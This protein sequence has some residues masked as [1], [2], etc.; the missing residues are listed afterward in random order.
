L[1]TCYVRPATSSVLTGPNLTYASE[2]DVLLLQLVKNNS[3]L[4]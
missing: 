3:I 2:Q 4:S 1:D